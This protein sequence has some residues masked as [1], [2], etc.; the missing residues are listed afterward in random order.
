M[1]FHAVSIDGVVILSF[2]WREY[3]CCV[4]PSIETPSGQHHTHTKNSNIGACV[5]LLNYNKRIPLLCLPA[6]G[7]V[8][9]R[10]VDGWITGYIQ[11]VGV[12]DL[13]TQW[14]S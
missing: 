11:F 5:V 14:V 3:K 9:C 7:L 4:G 6:G 8:G 2:S 10:I 1:V 12:F 13:G